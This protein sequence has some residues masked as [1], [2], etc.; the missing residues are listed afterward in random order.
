MLPVPNAEN[1]EDAEFRREFL[2]KD[3]RIL[4]LSAVSP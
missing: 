2:I 3:S 1:T 4:D